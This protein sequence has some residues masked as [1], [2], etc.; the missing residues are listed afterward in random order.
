M[1]ILSIDLGK[2]CGIAISIDGEIEDTEEYKFNGLLDLH[3]LVREKCNLWEPDVILIPYPT[4]HYY[5]IMSHAK[6][7]GVIEMEAEKRNI[8]V[9]EVQDSTCKKTVLGKGN[10]KKEDIANYYKKIHPDIK[11]EHILDSVMFIDWYLKSC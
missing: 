10:A 3:T 6:M 4:H 1:T 5:V 7:M 8:T 2:T 11:S 9:I